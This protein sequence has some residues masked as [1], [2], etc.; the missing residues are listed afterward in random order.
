MDTTHDEAPTTT[1]QGVPAL[2]TVEG[3]AMMGDSAATKPP[4]DGEE[5]EGP[6]IG[7][8]DNNAGR[9]GTAAPTAAVV[10]EERGEHTSGSS[11]KGG[12][13]GHSCSA[14]IQPDEMGVDATTTTTAT[15][16]VS[17]APKTSSDRD[18]EAEA[19]VSASG[20]AEAEAGAGAGAGSGSG[21]QGQGQ[22]VGTGTGTGS[23]SG[24]RGATV[25][26]TATAAATGT[27]T[28]TG[29]GTVGV[30]GSGGVYGGYSSS[31]VSSSVT[32]TPVI[33]ALLVMRWAKSVLMALN[34]LPGDSVLD[35]LVGTGV[36]CGRWGRSQV[37]TYFGVDP[38]SESLRQATEI[39]KI[40]NKT[41]QSEFI[42]NNPMTESLVIP[43]RDFDAAACFEVQSSLQSEDQ[44]FNLLNNVAKHIRV[45]GL[46]FGIV[47][48]S[49]EFWEQTV[50]KD[51][52]F[53][54]VVAG[55][56]FRVLLRQEK[57][58]DFGNPWKIDQPIELKPPTG[59]RWC[60]FA[61]FSS[62]IG[63]ARRAGLELCEITNL[64]EFYEEYRSTFSG[65]L[66]S[67]LNKEKPDEDDLKFL[68]LH[69]VFSFVKSPPQSDSL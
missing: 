31:V 49:S 27:G 18:K 29:T 65:E 8:N 54:R 50:K 11:D 16:A 56:V 28:G 55:K 62:W 3:D 34:V 17:V 58:T 4:G 24:A 14:E 52:A 2:G 35:V 7:G 25:A 37:G 22:G 48:D 36:D 1:T 46:F 60:Y 66:K 38:V 59:S 69:A 51:G 9:L 33:K 13:G 42:C 15:T 39:W 12:G 67:Y 26:A 30:G 63:L 40:R 64:C 68:G 44:A 61:R 43:R 32:K 23:G 19:A 57:F 45:G 47:P 6:P 20:G 10:A 5:G 53:S 21:E 41:V